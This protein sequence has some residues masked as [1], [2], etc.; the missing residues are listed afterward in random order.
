MTLTTIQNFNIT[1]TDQASLIQIPSK[2]TFVEAEELKSQVQQIAKTS[3]NVKKI[4]LDFGQTTL[5]DSSALIGLGQIVDEIKHVDMNLVFWSFS[6]EIKWILSFAGLDYL[7]QVEAG[8]EAIASTNQ[9]ETIFQSSSFHFSVLSRSKRLID[10]CGALVGLCITAILIIPI[11]IA[12]QLDNPGAILF[13]QIRCGHMGKKFRIWKFRSMVTN[14]EALMHEVENQVEGPLFKNE[15]D[16]RVTRVGKFLRKTSLDEFPQFWNVLKGEMSLVG[17]RPPTEK[18][19]ER[20]KI[21][22]GQR[23]DVKPGLTGEWQVS[24]R[25]HI[26]DFKDVLNLDLKYQQ[27]WSLLYDLELI[28]KTIGVIFSSKSG[29]C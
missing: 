5:I 8:T 19:V 22:Y 29:A 2:F 13:S 18:E 3:L 25:S 14:A 9:V 15:S 20:Y 4:I 10:I 28:F 7:W 6:E 23:L 24:G 1:N 17:T 16:P 21:V 27:N 26:K 11:A 12:I